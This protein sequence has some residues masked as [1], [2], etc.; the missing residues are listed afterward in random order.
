M[1]KIKLND[2][3]IN[4]LIQKRILDSEN[5]YE[6]IQCVKENCQTIHFEPKTLGMLFEIIAGVKPDPNDPFTYF[7]E[8]IEIA[9]LKKIHPEFQ[10]PNGSSWA[11]SDRGYLGN[12]YKIK[13][14]MKF[15]KTFSVKLD[16]PNKN[17]VKKHRHIKD[18]IKSKISNQRCKILDVGSNIEVDHKNGMYNDLSNILLENQNESDFQPLS[19]AA[20]DAK[21]EHCKKCKKDGKRYDAR[22]LGYKEGWVVGDENTD[23]CIG[24][25]WYD[26]WKFNNL[27]SQNF[28]KLK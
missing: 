8:E 25:Y 7:S 24:C 28:D 26:P 13:R 15:G 27:M 22:R 1:D 11:R 14:K 10:T 3:K 12:K 4:K 2:K 20:N 16:G 19:K 17:S 5:S 23:D 18:E 21:R 9:E 6:I